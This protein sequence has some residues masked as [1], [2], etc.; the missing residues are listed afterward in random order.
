ML[1]KLKWAADLNVFSAILVKKKVIIESF[2][3]D[4]VRS[5]HD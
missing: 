3:N 2:Q 5:K 4:Y 1:L